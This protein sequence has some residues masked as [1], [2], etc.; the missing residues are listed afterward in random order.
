MKKIFILGMGVQKAGTTWVHGYL[1]DFAE[2][3]FGFQKEYHVLDY[4]INAFKKMNIKRMMSLS[5]LQN[6][7]QEINTGDLDKISN[8][9]SSNL[10]TS[11][12]IT[13]EGLYYSYFNDLLNRETYITGDFTPEHAGL[14]KAKLRDIKNKFKKRGIDVFPLF[15]MRDPLE[16]LR[17]NVSMTIANKDIK[18]QSDEELTEIKN[19]QLTRRDRIKSDYLSTINNI[20]DVFNNN[21]FISFYEE[22]F[23]ENEVQKLTNALGLSYKKPKF[24]TFSNKASRSKADIDNKHAQQIALHYKEV[25]RGMYDMFGKDYIRTIWE[26]SKYID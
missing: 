16:R 1:S 12:M 4:N 5:E 8:R 9:I 22:V 20:K 14:T 7:H 13:H 11:S 10:M 18:I 17:S 19:Y 15:I 3:N 23:T 21:C 25:Y 26:S 2:V 24:K 6:F